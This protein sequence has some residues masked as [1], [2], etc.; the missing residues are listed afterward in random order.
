LFSGK[1]NQLAQI[2]R[3]KQLQYSLLRNAMGRHRDLNTI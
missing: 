1:G 2:W 3:A